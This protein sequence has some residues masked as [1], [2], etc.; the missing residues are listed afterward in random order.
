MVSLGA[1]RSDNTCNGGCPWTIPSGYDY[2]YAIYVKGSDVPPRPTIL[3]TP[4]PTPS[5]SLA[6][7]ASDTVGI[8]LDL[9]MQAISLSNLTIEAFK[10]AL[11]AVLPNITED[12]ITDFRILQNFSDIVVNG[13]NMTRRQLSD[14]RLYITA[15]VIIRASLAGVGYATASGLEDSITVTLSDAIDTGIFSAAVE[16]ECRCSVEVESVATNAIR[17]YPTLGPSPLP[18]PLPTLEPSPAPT[19]VPTV[20]CYSGQYF[21]G[22]SCHSCSIGRYQ[23]YDGPN[24]WPRNCSLCK[25][26]SIPSGL[27]KK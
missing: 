17:E 13:T 26:A 12:M 6:P 22:I 23:P 24:P 21:D 27:L 5:P 1:S 11:A 8:A 16:A 2:D 9:Q 18:T 4:T 15:E 19:P 7:T 14:Q 10:P 25:S 3:P 20:Q